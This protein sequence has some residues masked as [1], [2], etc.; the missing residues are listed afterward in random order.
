MPDVPPI[1]SAHRNHQRAISGVFP[2]V[3]EE[4]RCARCSVGRWLKAMG[5]EDAVVSKIALAFAVNEA[6]V[7][8]A[9]HGCR[10]RAI[11]GS[12]ERGGRVVGF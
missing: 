12:L 7:D 1:P 5:V 4:V 11:P 10:D 3:A 8:A 2:A 6:R 9:V